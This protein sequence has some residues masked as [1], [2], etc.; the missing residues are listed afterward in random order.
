MYKMGSYP[1]YLTA[2]TCILSISTVQCTVIHYTYNKTHCIPQQI[3]PKSLFAINTDKLKPNKLQSIQHIG[4]GFYISVLQSQSLWAGS[5]IHAW[6]NH[7]G[8]VESRSPVHGCHRHV[9]VIDIQNR[10]NHYLLYCG[11]LPLRSQNPSSSSCA[12]MQV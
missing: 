10:L 8:H 3:Y 1:N 6:L 5:T 11:N 2:I 7:R 9:Y 12:T 4:H